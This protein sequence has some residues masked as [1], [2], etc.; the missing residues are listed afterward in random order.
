M[1]LRYGIGRVKNRH[2]LELACIRHSSMPLCLQCTADG[3]GKT[4]YAWQHTLGSMNKATTV[5]MNKQTVFS[6]LLS[7]LGTFQKIYL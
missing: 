6:W 3:A 2:E 5:D 7:H 1:L 4:R